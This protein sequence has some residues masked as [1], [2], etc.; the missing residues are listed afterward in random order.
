MT[1]PPR[2]LNLA[3]AYAAGAAIASDRTTVPSE[4]ITL[5]RMFRLCWLS[6]SRYPSRVRWVGKNV[7]LTPPPLGC[8]DA[9]TIQ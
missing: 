9:L 3:R 2:S 4:M 5:V 7:V 8:R 6:A 1:L